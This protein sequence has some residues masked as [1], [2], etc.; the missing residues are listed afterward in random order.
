MTTIK[1]LQINLLK[2]IDR[3][4]EPQFKELPEIKHQLAE[5]GW[6]LREVNKIVEG[7]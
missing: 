7:K 2:R 4:N 5:I 6:I 3:L 1:D